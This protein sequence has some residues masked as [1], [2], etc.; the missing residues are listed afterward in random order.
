MGFGDCSV[1][2]QK[3]LKGQFWSFD[4][5]FA[6]I[7]FSVSITILAFTWFN[8]NSQLALSYG[9]GTL[10]MQ[11]QEQRLM[12][13]IITT[14]SP[15]NWENEINDTNPSTWSNISVGLASSP[16]STT[17]SGGKV[18]ALMAMADNGGFA[19]YQAT[20]QLLGIGYEYY[21]TIS[22]PAYT[23]SIGEN[24]SIYNSLT[25][26]TG[27]ESVFLGG[28]PAILK[29]VVWTNKPLAVS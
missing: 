11:I 20:K 1:L 8:I 21:I 2:K 7:I 6:I 9:N 22:D 19:N 18:Y 28:S 29:V 23:L 4:L 12:Q 26:Y 24:P 5:V 3:R 14:G 27:S 16:S 25:S 13:S 10:L 17:L 15:S